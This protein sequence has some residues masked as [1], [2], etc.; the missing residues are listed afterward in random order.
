MSRVKKP[1]KYVNTSTHPSGVLNSGKTKK[2]FGKNADYHKAKT[3]SDWLL[4]K[5]SIPYKTYRNKSKK[6]RKELRIEYAIDTG[7]RIGNGEDPMPMADMVKAAALQKIEGGVESSCTIEGVVHGGENLPILLAKVIE[8]VISEHV[9]EKFGAPEEGLM[10]VIKYETLYEIVNYI[11]YQCDSLQKEYLVNILE[12]DKEEVI[13]KISSN[14]LL[15]EISSRYTKAKRSSDELED[16]DDEPS[17]LDTDYWMDY[18]A[19]M[20][21]PFT[22]DGEPV[23]W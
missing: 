9:Y 18:M 3:L 5:Y 14:E 6:R 13:M 10:W 11:L 20:G 19:E 8:T 2:T 12:D 21:Y 22:D 23:G 15:T 17:S 7:N 4:I 1:N 16:Y